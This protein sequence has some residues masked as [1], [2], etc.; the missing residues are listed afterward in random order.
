MKWIA[1]Y[2]IPMLIAWPLW[3]VSH[4]FSI[5]VLVILSIAILAAS[6]RNP[7]N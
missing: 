5:V 3:Y 7:S 2:I 4:A 1:S 6:G